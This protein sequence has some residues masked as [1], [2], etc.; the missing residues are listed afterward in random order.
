MRWKV[1]YA[2]ATPSPSLRRVLTSCPNILTT[3]WLKCLKSGRKC[4]DRQGKAGVKTKIDAG[5][6][7]FFGCRKQNKYRSVDEMFWYFY[8]YRVNELVADTRC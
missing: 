2:L 7:S 5:G 6:Q 3:S 4:S 8:G 1:G